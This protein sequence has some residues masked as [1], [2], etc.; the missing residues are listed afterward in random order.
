MFSF[1]WVLISTR[2]YQ[3]SQSTSTF[4]QHSSCWNSDWLLVCA[5]TTT[6]QMSGDRKWTQTDVSLV[7]VFFSFPATKTL[8]RVEQHH[9]RHIH[10]ALW[11]QFLDVCTRGRQTPTHPHEQFHAPI[12]L[13]QCSVENVLPNNRATALTNL[14]NANLLL[15]QLNCIASISAQAHRHVLRHTDTS[16]H[17][18]HKTL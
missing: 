18:R 12:T 13:S 15:F 5:S 3:H 10:G 8:I 4:E 6:E 14:E 1:W 17:S 16:T 7:P 11:C 9:V 2:G